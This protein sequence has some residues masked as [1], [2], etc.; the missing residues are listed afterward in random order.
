[1]KQSA[2][3]GRD[4]RLL[5]VHGVAVLPDGTV[6]VS[7]KLDYR[8]KKFA[9]TGKLTATVGGRGRG[10]GQ[11]LGPGPLDS[12]GSR[13]A[14]ADFAGERVQCLV[15][16]APSSSFEA[17]GTVSDLCYD[18]AGQLWVLVLAADGQPGLFRYDSN[19]KQQKALTLRNARGDPFDHAGF[20]AWL[21]RGVIAVSYYVRNKIELWDTSGKFIREFS[22]PGL[23]DRARKRPVSERRS[24]FMVPDGNI[25]RSMTSDGNGRIYLLGAEYC[26]S[27]GREVLDLDGRGKLRRRILLADRSVLIRADRKGSLYA[28]P[29]TRDSIVRYQTAED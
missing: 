9:P 22:A 10:P 21:G 2:V 13:I 6:L 18:G 29:R 26:D 17:P 19:G 1:M 16:L 7:D 25:F 28:V 20:V 12:Y 3:I 23:P 11:F 14:V 5:A 8:V 15:N 4:S 27:P 24:D